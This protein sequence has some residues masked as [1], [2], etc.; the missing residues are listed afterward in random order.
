MKRIAIATVFLL[1]CG[2]ED[3][4]GQDG[5]SEPGPGSSLSSDE[6]ACD[7]GSPGCACANGM[8]LDP[9]VCLADECVWPPPPPSTSGESMDESSS[10][11]GEESTGGE[12]PPCS[13]NDQCGQA[14]VCN[15][16]GTCIFAR[17]ASFEIRVPN[18]N[19]GIGCDD[20][21]F[22]GDADL[23]WNLHLGT[24]DFGSST[25][26]QGGCPG[27]WPNDTICVPVNGFYDGFY[28]QARDEDGDYDPPADTL[29]W[30]NDEDGEPDPIGVR[31]LHDGVYDGGT[32]SG[33][34]LRVEFTVVPSCL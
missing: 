32:G 24:A 13:D 2:G 4:G 1:G 20:G 27:S 7:P 9:L 18:W 26:V 15:T 10:D 34:T 8:C 29:W 31:F 12:P 19:P 21:I 14:Q 17:D 6:G 23:Y 28:L 33:G 16:D 3:D 25:W 30:D 22:S 5:T 11:G